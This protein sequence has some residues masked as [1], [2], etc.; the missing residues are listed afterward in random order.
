MKLPHA[1]FGMLLA[2][3][4]TAGCHRDMSN[5]PYHRPLESSDFF[6]NGAA[7]RPLVPGTVPREASPVL[8]PVHT[9]A[10]DGQLVARIP[11][12]ITAALVA[13]GQERFNI[14]C[15]VCHGRDGYGE[16][17]IVQRGFPPPPS[18]H[19][20][21]LRRA[22]AGHFFDVITHGYGVM[23]PYGSRVSVGDRWAIVAYIRALQL[24]QHVSARA[25]PPAW[26][27]ELDREPPS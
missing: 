27:A 23:Y 19:T 7:S 12:A 4:L 24:S 6:D 10:Q 20:D 13:H 17:M 1:A 21:R 11:V 26:Q 2:A 5:Q 3:L 22:P 18:F 14:H 15:A 16:G 9:G 8:D 25:M